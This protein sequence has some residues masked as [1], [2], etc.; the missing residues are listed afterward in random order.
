MQI[1]L[2]PSGGRGEY[3]LAG[4]HGPVRGRELYGLELWLDFGLELRLPLY[5]VADIHDG[6]PRIRLDD[7]HTHIHASRLIA[8]VL[9]LPQPIREIRQTTGGDQVDLDRCA[10]SEIGVNVV[11]RTQSSAVLR[12]RSI[13]AINSSKASL[14]IDVL[15]RFEFVQRLWSS[16]APAGSELGDALAAH[17]AA[18]TSQPFI[19]KAVLSAALRVIEIQRRETP[20]L[21]FLLPERT[22]EDAEFLAPATT[23]ENDQSNPIQVNRA[24]RKRLVWRAERGAEGRN[25]KRLVGQAYHFK[26]AFTGL[27]L[28]PL[29]PG[30]LPGVDAAHIYPWSQL[31][32]NEVTNGI[33]LSKQMHW[34]FD[35]GILRLTF[36]G[37]ASAYV[38]ALGGEIPELANSVGFDLDTFARVCGPIPSGNLPRDPNFRPSPRALKLYNELMFP[39]I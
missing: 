10:F 19:H 25:F 39:N 18:C 30:F 2:R 33:C 29:A 34:A 37:N 17:Q 26:C 4:S 11:S 38:V 22:E 1:R 23:E 12:P 5:A 16:A 36:D 14:Q 13:I 35:E 27:R 6:K 28:P 24:I 31:G 32:S 15:A 9:L 21:Q 8:A 3:E 20:R 7:P